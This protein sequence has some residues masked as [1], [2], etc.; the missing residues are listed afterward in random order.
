MGAAIRYRVAIL[1]LRALRRPRNCASAQEQ[2]FLNM[3]L[4]IWLGVV[5]GIIAV[6][7]NTPGK[8]LIGLYVPVLLI[9]SD[10]FHAITPG[11][12]DPS[13]NV[14]VM[15]PI[16]F[17][18]LLAYGRDWKPSV[19]DM[20][21]IALAA[22]M[23]YS[24]YRAAGYSEAQ[25]LFAGTLFQIV[26][27]Y[28]VARLAID[29]EGL[30]VELAKR[31]VI[32]LFAIAL[33]GLFEFRFGWNPFLALPEKIF[34][35]QGLG[36]VTTFRYG[37]ARVAGPYAHCILA[38]MMMILA[39]RLS[40]WLEWGGHWEAK[41]QRFP[42]L[43]LSKGRL[44]TLAILVGSITTF[45][46]GPWLGGLVA[47]LFVNA[48]RH[49]K[50][51]LAFISVLAAIALIAL[52]GYIAFQAYIDVS[53]GVERTLSQ[54][55]A[56]YRKVLFE[57]YYAIALD[58]AWFGWGRNTWPKIPGMASIDNYYLLLSLMHGVLTTAVL[59][60]LM[61]WMSV[62]LF[63]KGLSEPPQTNSLAFTFLG[64]IIAFFIS[65]VTVYL[66]EN[67]VPTFFLLL[68]WA[69]GYM[70]GKGSAGINGTPAAA[71]PAPKFRFRVMR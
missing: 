36:W 6:T 11:L 44:I 38:G 48:G 69:E 12:P 15:M 61:A 40:R 10:T 9:I 3:H 8:A 29:R 27:P 14:A 22:L 7:R 4:I 23:A 2:R 26:A 58:H 5:A 25:N 13:A 54:E 50:R 64:I 56:M 28:L 57:K 46:R 17:A 70:R 32:I 34:S 16:F 71:D 45:A 20:L 68:G 19:A 55:T 63:L 67:V 30:H 59:L 51:K 35:G 33:I 66:G 52:P 65:L 1:N 62:R 39:Y 31:M 47:A 43:P 18:T 60:T 37:F 49:P 42:W 53:P 24:E 41:F 21:V